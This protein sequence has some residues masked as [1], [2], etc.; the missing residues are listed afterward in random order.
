VPKW[1]GPALLRGLS[2]D[3]GT[4]AQA[5]LNES[6]SDRY[7]RLLRTPIL[8]LWP[9]ARLQQE[10]LGGYTIRAPFLDDEFLRFAAT[11]PALSLMKGGYLRGLMREA[12]RGLVPEDLRLRETKGAWYWFVDQTLKRAG[13]LIVLGNLANT[14]RLADLG[15]VEPRTFKEVFEEGCRRPGDANYDELWRVL[16]LEAFIRQYDDEC[17]TRAA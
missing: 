1:A 7:A 17:A 6:P 10:V 15:L 3:A 13:G 12:M 2:D 16:S 5:T 8:A 4:S 9:L 14:R 11:L